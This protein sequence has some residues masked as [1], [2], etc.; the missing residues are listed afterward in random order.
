[1]RFRI[2]SICPSSASGLLARRCTSVIRASFSMFGCDSRVRVINWMRWLILA[3]TARPRNSG[4]SIES[5]SMCTRAEARYSSASWVTWIQP[6]MEM[7]QARTSASQ[8]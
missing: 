2:C 8:R 7:T 4:L 5:V 6:A 1:M 3:S